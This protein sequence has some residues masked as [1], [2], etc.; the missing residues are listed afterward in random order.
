VN[1]LTSLTLVDDDDDDDDD[2]DI[3]S[4]PLISMGHSLVPYKVICHIIII[5]IIIIIRRIIIII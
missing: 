3:F 4:V 2:D 5:I 1:G